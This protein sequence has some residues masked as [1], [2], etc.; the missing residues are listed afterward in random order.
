MNQSVV[1]TALSGPQYDAWLGYHSNCQER[2][3][4]PKRRLLRG[5]SGIL[6]E[7]NHGVITTALTE[8][9]R[10]L[11]KLYGVKPSV[12]HLSDTQQSERDNNTSAP[13]DT[14]RYLDRKQFGGWFVQ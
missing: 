9:S 11:E 4:L 14:N 7:E 13:S 8:L 2:M 10:G 5:A 3:D 6:M 1:Q 12:S